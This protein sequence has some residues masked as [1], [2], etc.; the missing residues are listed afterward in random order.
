MDEHLLAK[1]YNIDDNRDEGVF[2]F[3]PHMNKGPNKQGPQVSLI[4]WVIRLEI[5]PIIGCL[6]IG[7]IINCDL[8]R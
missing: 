3:F 4:E 6:E 8:R 1:G 2:I 5:G 7:H